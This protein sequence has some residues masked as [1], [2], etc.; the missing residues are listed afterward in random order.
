M[1]QKKTIIE[2]TACDICGAAIEADRKESIAIG[3]SRWEL[4][5]CKKDLTALNKQFA[6]W[7][8]TARRIGSS[9]RR[10]ARQA[11]G[12]WEYL[13]SLGFTRH[14]GRKSAAEAAAL[15]KRPI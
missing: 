6:E 12:E 5:L 13:E 15:D 3:S 2:T 14:R 1:V 8:K 4:D 11:Q 9:G 7:T 10:S